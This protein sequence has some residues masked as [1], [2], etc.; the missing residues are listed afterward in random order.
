MITLSDEE[1]REKPDSTLFWGLEMTLIIY[2]KEIK[3]V[4]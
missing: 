1:Q 4:E 2:S 3:E